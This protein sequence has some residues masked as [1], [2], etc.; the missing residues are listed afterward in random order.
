M[1]YFKKIMACIM[2]SIVLI[3]VLSFSVSAK[4]VEYAPYLGY[5]YDADGMSI[6]APITYEYNRVVNNKN[7]GLDKA[8]TTPSD[9]CWKNNILYIL[10]SGNSRILELD[11]DLNFKSVRDVFT[12]KSGASISFKGAKGF[13]VA[14]NGELYIADTVGNRILVFDNKNQ[15]IKQITKPDP[16]I[17]G[18]DYIFDV[19]KV[20]LNNQGQL[21]VVAASVNDGLFTFTQE[22]EFLYFFGKNTILQTAEVL[23]NQIKKLFL[24]R[25]QL[26]KIKNYT[27]TAVANF[28]IDEKGF[29]YTIAEYN[30]D[31]KV[32]SVRKINFKGSNIFESHGVIKSFGDLEWDRLGGQSKKTSFIDVDVDDDGFIHLLDRGKG[33]VFQYSEDGQL[34]SVFGGYGKQIGMFSEPMAIETINNKVIVL[35]SDGSIIEFNPTEYTDLLRTAFKDLD[36]SN[37]TQA[38]ETWNKVLAYNSNSLYPYYGLGMAYEKL[39]D[40]K[41]AME[42]FKLSSS[43]EEYSDAFHEYRKQFLGDY[44]WYILAGVVAVVVIVV[45]LLKI[46][47]KKIKVT[48]DDAYSV[49]EQKYTFPLYTLFHPADGFEQFKYRRELPSYLVSFVI[50]IVFF[51]VRVWQYFGTGYCFNN[52]TAED[53]SV[54]ATLLG[55]VIIYILFVVGNWAVCSLFDGNGTIKEIASATAYALIPYILSQFI[56][57]A[58]SNILTIDEGI[59]LT[60]ITA[61]GV[62]WSAMLI[63]IGL[64]TVNQYYIGKTILTTLL[65]FFAMIVIALIVFLFFSLIQQVI[66]FFASIWNEYQLR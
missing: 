35:D 50:I 53:Y 56:C 4:K 48:S 11:A 41:T 45:F 2:T 17:I 3:S 42:N 49:L 23:L 28:D 29:V 46:I 27:P 31:E 44:L 34:I 20:L 22:G 24:T 16:S 15:L 65:T 25:E 6:A 62:I 12:D 33:R 32:R 18:F 40:Y 64:S 19:S 14:D 36:T 1:T 7:L 61:I 47:A 8:L 21:Y 51:F 59:T 54:L 66:Y 30:A 38:I 43:K 5:E 13:T 52:N 63:I 57:V 39:G 60:I 58:L 9:M 37:P 10:D 26:S 55:T